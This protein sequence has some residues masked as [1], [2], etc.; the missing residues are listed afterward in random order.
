MTVGTIASGCFIIVTVAS[1]VNAAKICG[2]FPVDFS[3]AF[4]CFCFVGCKCARAGL[5]MYCFAKIC[6]LCLDCNMELFKLEDAD[7]HGVT[8]LE[9][10]MVLIPGFVSIFDLYLLVRGFFF[11]LRECWAMSVR[12]LGNI[13]KQCCQLVGLK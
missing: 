6:C 4:I 5:R 7:P 2:N 10:L 8:F 13:D 12:F 11:S 9:K 1:C 3:V